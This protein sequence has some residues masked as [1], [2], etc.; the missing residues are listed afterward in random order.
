[1]HSEVEFEVG[2]HVL[3]D[4]LIAEMHHPLPVA[5]D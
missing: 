3:G 5:A 2:E 1:L 4:V